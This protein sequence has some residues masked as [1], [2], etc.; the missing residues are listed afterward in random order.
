MRQ[1][2]DYLLKA[3]GVEVPVSPPVVA[4]RAND[5]VRLGFAARDLGEAGRLVGRDARLITN[6]H[7]PGREVGRLRIL[8][9]DS[10]IFHL[11][12]EVVPVEGD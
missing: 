2:A 7:L 9:T 3:D 1:L 11:V 6:I 4:G 8:D 5:R 12:A 10:G